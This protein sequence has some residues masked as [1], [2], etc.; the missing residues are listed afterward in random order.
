MTRKKTVIITGGGMS[1]IVSALRLSRAGFA[2]VLIE[3]NKTLG[4]KVSQIKGN[5]YTFELIPS[6][7]E[8]I[9]VY[10]ELFKYLGLDIKKYLNFKRLESA[11]KF[12]FSDGT[13]I[14]AYRD[15]NKLSAEFNKFEKNSYKKINRFFKENK[16]KSAFIKN[17]ILGNNSNPS[18][19][20]KLNLTLK[21]FQLSILQKYWKN[22]DK[23]F[24]SEKVK[25]ILSFY[26]AYFSI[27]PYKDASL[28][29]VIPYE[30]LSKGIYSIKGG[31]SSVIDS[32]EIILNEMKVKVIKGDEVSRLKF[33][34][35]NITS[36]KLKSGKEIKGDVFLSDIN[37][38]DFNKRFLSKKIPSSYINKLEKSN[39][40]NSVIT[41]YL[42]LNKKFKNLEYHNFYIN[43]NLQSIV[44]DLKKIHNEEWIPSFYFVNPSKN[45]DTIAPKGY[46]ALSI[47]ISVPNLKY[48]NN[49]EKIFP[50]IKDSIYRI[51]E[52][53][54]NMKNFKNSIKFEKIMYPK[55]WINKLSLYKG[56]ILGLIPDYWNP[57]NL[58]SQKKSKYLSNL[59]FSSV[60]D[61]YSRPGVSWE[62]LNAKIVSE[63]IISNCK[64]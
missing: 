23:Y 14:N 8:Y 56:S 30:E 16:E 37:R 60:G 10:E 44:N 49:W 7:I 4:G 9:E 36:V 18:I 42:G 19:T 57:I 21:Y 54:L 2:V 29:T 48:R 47:L 40:S 41:I 31:M 28:F 15:K 50:E 58:V 39:L 46:T 51:M 1:G 24:T 63:K 62:I 61:I 43:N 59:Y 33:N 27:D 13:Y 12:N 5:G 17:N 20:S 26:N 52:E 35:R 45:D 64:V 53:D 25:L 32:F 22:I 34:N 38:I 3:K 55:D 6:F 11:Y